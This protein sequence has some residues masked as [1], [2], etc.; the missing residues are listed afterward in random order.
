MKL[1]SIQP[2]KITFNW[3]F[4]KRCTQPP[5][6]SNSSPYSQ[7]SYAGL[8]TSSSRVTTPGSIR[9]YIPPPSLAFNFYPSNFSH[10]LSIFLALGSRPTLPLRWVTEDEAGEPICFGRHKHRLGHGGSHS[11]LRFEEATAQ[12]LHILRPL[13]LSTPSRSLGPLLHSPQIHPFVFVDYARF[14]CLRRRNYRHHRSRRCRYYSP[15]Q[16]RV[17]HCFFTSKLGAIL[18][19]ALFFLRWMK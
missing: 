7:N 8:H 16:I 3:N 15:L 14:S 6:E 10:S 12:R 1:A 4:L 5:S 17:C 2:Q 18:L 19:C 9:N 11:L 13:S